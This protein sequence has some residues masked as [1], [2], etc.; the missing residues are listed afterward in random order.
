MN[1]VRNFTLIILLLGYILLSGLFVIKADVTESDKLAV[2]NQDA[3]YTIND[4]VVNYG[5]QLIGK[6][7]EFNNTLNIH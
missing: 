6:Y 3:G 5:Q 7:E 1:K 2:I 4:Q